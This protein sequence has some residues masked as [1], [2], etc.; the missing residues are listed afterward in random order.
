VVRTN[1]AFKGFIAAASILAAVRAAAGR[2]RW[3]GPSSVR[4]K[5]GLINTM[6]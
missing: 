6:Y 2:G 3:H 4:Q 5:T 1:S